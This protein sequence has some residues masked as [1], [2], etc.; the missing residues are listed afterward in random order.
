MLTTD[1]KPHGLISYCTN[2][3]ELISAVWAK[4]QRLEVLKGYDVNVHHNTELMFLMPPK[5]SLTDET[6]LH[7]MTSKWARVNR[8]RILNKLSLGI[9]FVVFIL[10]TGIVSY[11]LGM[12]NYNC[13]SI[14]DGVNGATRAVFQDEATCMLCFVVSFSFLDRH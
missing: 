8:S 11:L 6:L 5:I 1:A 10:D 4:M 7:S 13:E 3:T 2:K 12:W 9:L 14:P